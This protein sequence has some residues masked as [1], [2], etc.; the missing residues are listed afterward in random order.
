MDPVYLI[1]VFKPFNI[2][3]FHI[4]VGCKYVVSKYNLLLT[5]IYFK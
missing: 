4:N 3:A 5:S 2:R 1:E